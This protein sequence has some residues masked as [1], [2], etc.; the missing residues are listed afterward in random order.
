MNGEGVQMESSATSS[1]QKQ[2][3]DLRVRTAPISTMQANVEDIRVHTSDHPGMVLVA[4]PLEGNNSLIWSRFV[5]V[6]LTAK[7]KLSSIDG[8]YPKPAQGTDDFK[9]W[10]RT[11]SM[12]FSWIMNCISNDISKA[13]Y[14]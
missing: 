6:A 14:Y 7:M 1:A 12:A 11:S 4:D 8:M 13:F 9:Q 2:L 10:I 5:K 3:D